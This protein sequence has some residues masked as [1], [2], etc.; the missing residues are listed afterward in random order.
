MDIIKILRELS[1]A[2][3]IGG[4]DGALAVAEGYLSQFATVRRSNNSLIASIKG[5][6]D[7]KILLD[8]HIDEIGM[9]VVGIDGGFVRVAAA[10]GIDYRM[11]AGMR[12]KLHGKS[13]I[14]G[15]FCSVPP[16]L[17]KDESQAPDLDN[18]YIDTGLSDAADVISV[19]D[20]VTFC[21][22]F[23]ELINGRV[24]GKALDNRAGVAALIYSAYLL[25]GK[26]VPYSVDILLSDMEELGGDGAKVEAYSLYPDE[27]IVVDVSFGDCPDVP[28]DKTGTLGMGAM[29]G[30]SPI[31]SDEITKGLMSVADKKGIKQQTEVMGGRTSTNADVVTV[32]K[33]GVKT[34][35]LSIP[36]K[37]M[38]TPIEVIEVSDVLATAELITEYI[39]SKED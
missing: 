35:L 8:A 6:S 3:S 7:K 26:D 10:G 9:M 21:Q 16:H 15:V 24:T 33:A 11:L 19:G 23:K 22:S 36:L 2:D 18:L 32:T 39:L 31:L 14:G 13:T 4:V 27:A 20:R 34:G 5:R 30:I 25:S 29:I 37:N 12:V 38:H 1:E 17:S 28:S